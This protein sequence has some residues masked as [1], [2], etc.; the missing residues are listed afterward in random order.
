MKA[1]LGPVPAAV[2]ST[3]GLVYFSQVEGGILITVG[4]VV[5]ILVLVRFVDRYRLPN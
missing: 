2:V 4:I 1:R 3:T 5:C